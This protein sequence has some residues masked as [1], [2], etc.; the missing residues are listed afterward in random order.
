M[1]L[2]IDV[3]TPASFRN[4]RCNG[5]SDSLTVAEGREEA[6]GVSPSVGG[7]D[8]PYE[9]QAIADDRQESSPL[10]PDEQIGGTSTRISSE[11][12]L[13]ANLAATEPGVRPVQSASEAEQTISSQCNIRGPL[14]ASLSNEEQSDGVTAHLPGGCKLAS[15]RR[16][17]NRTSQGSLSPATTTQIQRPMAGTA[18]RRPRLP[19]DKTEGNVKGFKTC[20]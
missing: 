5:P 16:T 15:T 13:P 2:C 20:S 6:Q 1:H 4:L 3:S 19:K 9:S 8:S 14:A 7:S 10:H 11:P 12:S 17:T 18:V